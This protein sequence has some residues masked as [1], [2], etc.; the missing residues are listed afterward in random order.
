[1]WNPGYTQ[2]ARTPFSFN[3]LQ[4]FSTCGVQHSFQ[5]NSDR[6]TLTELRPTPRNKY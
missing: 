2:N 5:P 3:G 6:T 1:M 4:R